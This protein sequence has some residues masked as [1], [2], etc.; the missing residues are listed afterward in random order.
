VP[1]KKVNESVERL[2]YEF[3]DQ[4][5]SSAVLSLQWEK[6]KIPFTISVDLKKVQIE[7]FR[8]EINSGMF[9]RYWQNMHA[10]ANYC[11]VN[12]INLEEGLSWAER[13]VN[14]FFG[15]ANFLTLSTYAGLLENFNRKRE[16][17]SLMNKAFPMANPMQLLIYGSGLN[18]RK[19]H[20]EAFT[21]FKMN[22][23]KNPKA[24]YANLGMVMGYYFLDNRKEALVYAQNARDK[25]ADANWKAYFNSLITT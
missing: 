15:E 2:K 1:V 19:K 5:D 22:Y 18:K 24:D 4:T 16:A 9:Y 17:D 8:R 13:S 20:Q 10:A 6:V 23:D 7:S 11:L 25:T 12:N 3:V 14:P 21:I